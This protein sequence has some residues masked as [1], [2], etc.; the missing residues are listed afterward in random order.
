MKKKRAAVYARVSTADKKQNPRTQLKPLRE[1][2]KNRDFVITE[3]VDHASGKKEDRPQYQKMLAGV[4]RRNF[5][6]VLVWRYDRFARST[7]Q[8]ITQLSF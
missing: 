3:F 5:D 6:V 1:Y 7:H 4:R 8:L 2:A